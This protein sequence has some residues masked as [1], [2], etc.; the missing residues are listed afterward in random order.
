MDL[1]VSI[2]SYL[3]YAAPVEEE[4]FRFEG[5]EAENGG[6]EQGVYTFV[7]GARLLFASRRRSGDEPKESLQTLNGV[8]ETVKN[9]MEKEGSIVGVS[10]LKQELE[11][12]QEDN[13]RLHEDMRREK[14]QWDVGLSFAS[15]VVR[16]A[17]SRS[18]FAFALAGERA[19]E[20]HRGLL[21][22]LAEGASRQTRFTG[23]LCRVS[24]V[25]EGRVPLR[26]H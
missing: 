7:G 17:V 26:V 13:E 23:V 10:H 3:L 22:V 9:A 24:S 16:Q 4:G 12:A 1:E 20:S 2:C 8:Q 14:E 18:V 21:R 15:P 19:T 6:A 11:R 5:D 25:C